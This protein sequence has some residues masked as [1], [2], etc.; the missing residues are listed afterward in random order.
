VESSTRFIFTLAVWKQRNLVFD[1]LGMSRKRK[2]GNVE[3]AKVPKQSKLSF[4]PTAPT[5]TTP[6]L[7]TLSTS[8]WI[9]HYPALPP[10][11]RW[12]DADF[13]RV[14]SLHPSE[15]GTVMIR[16]KVTPT[17]RYEDKKHCIG[18]H[19]DNEKQLIP[20]APIY[21]FSF[22]A[23]RRFLV[24]SKIKK[25]DKL[26]F[27]MTNNSLVVMG[28]NTQQQYVHSVPRLGKREERNTPS[29]VGRRINVTF[30]FFA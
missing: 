30:R 15:L 28:G 29:M 10:E 6:I 21:S 3:D 7:H 20:G 17:P 26:A 24:K 9:R 27:V 5:P 14:W 1:E 2:P 22:G 4:E 16:G 8:S 18:W 11:L 12:T 19:S 13:E 25:D 23:T